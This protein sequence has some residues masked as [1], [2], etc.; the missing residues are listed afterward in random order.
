MQTPV[1]MDVYRRTM[2]DAFDERPLIGVPTAFQSLF[3]GPGSQTI[4]STVADVVD[5]DIVRGNERIAALVQRGYQNETQNLSNPLG[6]EH[7]HSAQSRLYPLIETLSPLTTS[8]VSKRMAGENP[9][10]PTTKTRIQRELAVKITM[11]NMA[12]T[13]RRMETMAAEAILTGKITTVDGGGATLQYDFYRSSDLANTAGTVW[14][15]VNALPL[16]DLDAMCDELRSIGHVRPDICIMAGDAFVE[17]MNTT[18]IKNAADNRRYSFIT[19]GQMGAIPAKY[20]KLLD[21]GMDC[22]GRVVTPLGRELYIFV[23]NEVYTNTAGSATAYMTAGKVIVMYSGARLDRYF[24]PSDQLEM[25]SSRKAWVNELF[26]FNMDAPPVPRNILGNVVSG[27]MFYA[28]AYGPDNGKSVMIRT[29]AAPIF[30]T[31]Q[32]D[33]IGVITV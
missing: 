15:D 16:A 7:A 11:E 33:A 2:A 20:S 29:Q 6:V 14:S 24:G 25:P 21:G 18:Q 4:Y 30:A 28:D 23:Y 13:V 26:G 27:A 32:T 5:I 3:G 17:F 22:V 31:T 1:V 8:M 9:Y 12:K 19:L 10:D